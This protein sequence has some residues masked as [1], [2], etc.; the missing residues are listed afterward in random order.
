MP[1]NPR[2]LSSFLTDALRLSGQASQA[3]Q[4][5]VLEARKG[6]VTP[7]RVQHLYQVLHTLKGTASMVHGCGKVVEAIHHVEARLATSALA[8]SAKK[9]DWLPAAREAVARGHEA[10]LEIQAQAKA[11]APQPRPSLKGILAKAWLGDREE[12]LWFPLSSLIKVLAPDVL[13]DR[14]VLCVQGNWVPV[15][16]AARP[17]RRCVGLVAQR[18]AATAVV[19]AHEVV[20]VVS[21][22]VAAQQG[23]KAGIDF[24][25][26]GGAAT[27]SAA[28]ESPAA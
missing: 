9:L 25:F 18:D 12:L 4:A 20:S 8:D 26:S 14:E 15:L 17:A 7:A 24:V 22:T 5:L 16:G 2:V 10:L 19:A 23:A 13:G 11:S 6:S 27:S 21:W 3:V 28:A 1:A